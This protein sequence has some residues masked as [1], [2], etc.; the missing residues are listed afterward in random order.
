MNLALYLLF[1]NFP[2]AQGPRR[3]SGSVE[4][5]KVLGALENDTEAN[6]QESIPGKVRFLKK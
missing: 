6:F 1:L 3:D 5:K 4:A 2:I